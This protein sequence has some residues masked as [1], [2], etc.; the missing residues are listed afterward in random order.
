M[1]FYDL[2]K[3]CHC[4]LLKEVRQSRRSPITSRLIRR[5]APRNDGWWIITVCAFVFL[6]AAPGVEASARGKVSAGNSHYKKGEY[7]KSL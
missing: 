6:C 1:N 2:K 5:F 3:G 4:E 7:D